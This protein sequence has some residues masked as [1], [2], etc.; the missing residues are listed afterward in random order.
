[1]VGEAVRQG[2][3]IGLDRLSQMNPQM[4]LDAVAVRLYYAESLS[5]VNYLVKEFGSDNFARLCEGLRDK[6]SLIKAIDYA[7]PFRDLKELDKAWQ[8]YLSRQ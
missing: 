1:M 6:R 3:L 4:M 5:V 8:E 7:Y 2:S